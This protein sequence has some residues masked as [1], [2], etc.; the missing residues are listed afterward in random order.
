MAKRK[1]AKRPHRAGVK[2][3]ARKAAKK[4][5]DGAKLYTLSEVSKK[6][7]ISMPT[8]QKYKRL[9]QHRIPSVGKGRKQRYPQEALAAFQK[10]KEENL[11]KRGRPRKAAAS[12]RGRAAKSAAGRKH[13][14]AGDGLLSLSEIA[15]RTRISY[16]TLLRY[17][18][19]YSSRIPFTGRGRGKRYPEAAIAVFQKL[20]GESRRGP[21]KGSG[22]ASRRPAKGAR[23]GAGVRV[24]RG[25]DRALAARIKELERMQRE[26]ARQ[27][28]AVLEVLRKP[29]QVTIRPE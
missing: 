3:P 9:Y 21:K 23:G 20:R 22:R 7:G 6:T 8:V 1:A 26:L 12:T 28:D 11:K 10:I 13:A 24:A 27:L 14:A 25:A 2:R 29:L 19:L 4:A 18:K 5:G 15:R 16:P 17:V